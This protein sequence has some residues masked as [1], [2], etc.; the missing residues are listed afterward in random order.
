MVGKN[1]VEYLL[2]QAAAVFESYFAGVIL[3][4]TIDQKDD[5]VQ[6]KKKDGSYAFVRLLNVSVQEIEGTTVAIIEFFEANN[7][8]ILKNNLIETQRQLLEAQDLTQIG[9]WDY[10]LATQQRYWS[11]MLYKMMGIG[12]QTFENEPEAFD[13]FIIQSICPTHVKTYLD[14]RDQAIKTKKEAT[15]FYKTVNQNQEIIYLKEIVKPR[16]DSHQNV[17]GLYGTTQNITESTAIQDKLLD[18]EILFRQLIDNFP[19]GSITIYNTQFE[20]QYIGGNALKNEHFDVKTL[21]GKTAHEVIPNFKDSPTEKA[22]LQTRH[23]KQNQELEI[24]YGQNTYLLNLSPVFDVDN[25]TIKYISIYSVL[26]N[27]LKQAQQRAEQLSTNLKAIVE[28]SQDNIFALNKQYEYILFNENHRKSMQEDYGTEVQINKNIFECITVEADL[29]QAKK[30]IKLPFEGKP[31]T[32]ITEYGD[33]NRNA[34]FFYE[35]TGYPIYDQKNELSGIAVF[36]KNISE[37]QNQQQKIIDS[38]N[39][40]LESQRLARI[41][42]WEYYFETKKRIWSEQIFEVLGLDKKLI[43]TPEILNRKIVKGIHPQ[44]RHIYDQS[45]DEA[46]KKGHSHCEHRFI[47]PDKTVIYLNVITQK[48]LSKNGDTVGLYGIIQD[49]TAIRLAE[50]HTRTQKEFY[51]TIL[52]NITADIAILDHN[53]KY[54]FVNPQAIKNEKVRHE[55]IGKTDFEWAALRAIDP[56]VA[57]QRLEKFKKTNK[58]KKSLQW[59]EIIQKPKDKTATYHLRTIVP[60]LDEQTKLVNY[61]IG[62]GLDI[63]QRIMAEQTLEKTN[64]ILERQNKFLNDFVFSIAHDL[65]APVANLKGLSDVIELNPNEIHHAVGRMM[66]STN[67]LEQTLHGLIQII[68][69]QTQGIAMAQNIAIRPIIDQMIETCGTKSINQKNFITKLEVENICYV[70]PYLTSILQN[71]IHNAIKYS[72]TNRTLEVQISTKKVDGYTLLTVADNGMGIDLKLYKQDLFKPFK[73]YTKER[74]GTGI[75]LS[76]IKNMIEQ[77]DGKIEVESRLGQGTQFYV[78]MK[79]YDN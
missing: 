62:Y 3:N 56:S 16:L 45:I 53:F 75:G 79:A 69:V 40:L 49:I 71:L 35:T 72:A 14:A 8:I 70:L 18:S 68:E 37:R 41:G 64:K 77:N 30:D 29:I 26:V 74:E 15:Y 54:I 47:K 61:Y 2:P 27:S 17:V 22:I 13:R 55:I 67:R 28:G 65:R 23:T 10:T 52:N 31:H 36:A 42:S 1:I 48:M 5:F 51:E 7:E 11:P 20:I 38:E 24:A 12:E 6:I 57:H 60:V 34:R 50:Q 9:N 78:Y 44:D 32:S 21:I 25:T 76:I 4:Q 66:L 58:T 46:L 39:K 33:Q 43:D 63:T 19:N 59:E 73:R